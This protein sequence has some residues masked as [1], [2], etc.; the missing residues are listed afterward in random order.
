MRALVFRASLL[1]VSLAS[2]ASSDGGG[3]FFASDFLGTSHEVYDDDSVRSLVEGWSGQRSLLGDHGG[4]RPVS[5]VGHGELCYR[6][7]RETSRTI[8][9]CGMISRAHRIITISELASC[10][11]ARRRRRARI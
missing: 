5:D 2:A 7:G 1:L 3:P 10:A 8:C 6:G 9:S 4:R 11:T